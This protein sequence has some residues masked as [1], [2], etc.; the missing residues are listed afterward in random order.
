MD[1]EPA[2]QV[3]RKKAVPLAWDGSG[4]LRSTRANLTPAFFAQARRV[5]CE[6]E[7][8]T[9]S[10]LPTGLRPG[11]LPDCIA[12]ELLWAADRLAPNPPPQS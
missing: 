12:A 8:Y 5:F 4:P 1:A 9:Y 7:T 2:V 11:S 6:V 3:P 10:V